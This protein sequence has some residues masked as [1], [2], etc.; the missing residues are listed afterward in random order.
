M[1]FSKGVMM[2]GTGGGS[3]NNDDHTN[4]EYMKP[5]PAPLP[6]GGGATERELESFVGDALSSCIMLQRYPRCVIQVVIQIVQADGSVP[7]VALNCAVLAL[8]DASVAM[9]V[10]PVATTC[11]VVSRAS[12]ESQQQLN[13]NIN[14]VWMDPSAEEESADGHS[15]VVFV[16]EADSNDDGRV[17]EIVASFTY[18]APV[19]M[20]GLLQCMDCYRMYNTAIVTFAR[21]ALEHK[22]EQEV[23]T[24]WS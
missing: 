24:L 17:P 1:V 9:R 3:S 10:I 7:G 5:L 21:M 11:A 4:G 16:T 13:D 8:M 6:S 14:S 18:G 2:A 12:E 22:V 15:I 19:A 23:K 20:S